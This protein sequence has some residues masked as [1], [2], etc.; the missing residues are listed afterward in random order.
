MLKLETFDDV[1]ASVV[2]EI[3][4]MYSTN[5]NKEADFEFL[6]NLINAYFPFGYKNIP[7]EIMLYKILYLKELKKFQPNKLSVHYL[8]NIED[9]ENLKLKLDGAEYEGNPY[10]VSVKTQSKNINILATLK[11]NMLYQ[12]EYETTLLPNSQVDFLTIKPYSFY[13]Q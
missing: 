12:F 8:A 5:L 7:K 2:K 11:H 4:A 1:N 3:I 9:I 13:V 10:V 6:T